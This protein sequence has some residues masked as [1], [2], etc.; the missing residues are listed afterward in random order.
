MV[1]EAGGSRM[2]DFDV[3]EGIVADSPTITVADLVSIVDEMHADEVGL[4]LRTHMMMWF[5][6]AP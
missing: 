6:L 2:V 5:E 1:A 3:E 4:D